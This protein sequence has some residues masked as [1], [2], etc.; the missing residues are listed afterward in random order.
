LIRITQDVE[1][2]IDEILECE[3]IA[4]SSLHGLIASDSYGIPNVRLKIS[5][6]IIG[7]DF[8]FEDYY[9]GVSISKKCIRVN[10]NTTVHSIIDSCIYSKPQFD[11]NY[12][13]N[14]LKSL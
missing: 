10:E 11:S 9:E 1:T 12:M 7:G 4:S 2:F 3:F 13:I 14:S 8:K 6:Q 5:D